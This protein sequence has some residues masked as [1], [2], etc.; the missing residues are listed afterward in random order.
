MRFRLVRSSGEFTAGKPHLSSRWSVVSLLG[1]DTAESP[2]S[3]ASA[4]AAPTVLS[5]E[6]SDGS[7]AVPSVADASCP[8]RYFDAQTK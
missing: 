7:A 2:L 8:G 5:P 6:P 3:V 4:D 1:G